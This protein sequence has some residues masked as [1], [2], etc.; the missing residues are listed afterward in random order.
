M[1]QK[2]TLHNKIFVHYAFFCIDKEEGEGYTVI[3]TDRVK[4][5]KQS[6]AESFSTLNQ[7]IYLVIRGSVLDSI[8]FSSQCKMR[9]EWHERRQYV[10]LPQFDYR[11]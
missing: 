3:T 5:Q 7:A 6:N 9:K 4:N 11:I 8:F 2:N 10:I 1:N